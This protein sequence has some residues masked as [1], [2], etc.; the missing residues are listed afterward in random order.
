MCVVVDAYRLER[1]VSV[2]VRSSVMLVSAVC[3]SALAPAPRPRAR[4]YYAERQNG[5]SPTII[6]LTTCSMPCYGP[7]L[8]AWTH[9]P[10]LSAAR[11]LLKP[12]TAVVPDMTRT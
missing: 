6:S 7:V 2:C 12:T 4:D 8:R 5:T 1:L 10:L 3:V 11:A 9:R